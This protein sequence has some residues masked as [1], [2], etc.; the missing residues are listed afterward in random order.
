[1]VVG[2][3]FLVKIL[4]DRLVQHLNEG[5]ALHEGQAD[6]RNCVDNVY[7]LNKIVQEYN[8]IFFFPGCTES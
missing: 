7:T 8:I 4:N 1:M 6:F 3:F 2:K 5:Q